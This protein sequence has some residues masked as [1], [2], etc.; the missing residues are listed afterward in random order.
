MINLSGWFFT[1][2]TQEDN[3]RDFEDGSF[4]FLF[5]AERKKKILFHEKKLILV[6]KW[7]EENDVLSLE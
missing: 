5:V 3:E 1:G 6:S 7:D 2:Y 4:F